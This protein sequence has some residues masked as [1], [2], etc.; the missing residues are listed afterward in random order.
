MLHSANPQLGYAR[1]NKINKEKVLLQEKLTKR[2]MREKK[3]KK[4]FLVVFAE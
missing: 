3:K 4:S 2:L 1:C